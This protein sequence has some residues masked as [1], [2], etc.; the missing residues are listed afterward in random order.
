MK[1]TLLVSFLIIYGITVQAQSL[2][3]SDLTNMATF[4]MGRA[5]VFLT[6]GKPFKQ[7]YMEDKGKLVIHHYKGITPA[8]K[9]ETVVVGDGFVTASGSLLHSVTYTSTQTKYVLNLLGQAH[10]AGFN[11]NFLGADAYKKIYVYAST[12]YTM[13]IFINLDNSA[14]TV[15]VK[16]NDFVTY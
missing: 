15:E 6:Q 3:L 7:I 10:A 14:G 13:R 1:K 12:L 9:C 8:S 4:D 5:N 16:Q 11:R 2:S